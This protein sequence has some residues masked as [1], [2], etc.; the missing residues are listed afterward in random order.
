MEIPR[1]YRNWVKADDRNSTAL[2]RTGRRVRGRKRR[3]G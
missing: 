1:G 2:K 3:Q